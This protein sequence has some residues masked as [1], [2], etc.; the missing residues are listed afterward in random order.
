M[1]L[2]EKNKCAVETSKKHLLTL[3]Q[4]DSAAIG[5]TSI[6]HDKIP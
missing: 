4:L 2:D 3:K 6:L 1:T 5:M